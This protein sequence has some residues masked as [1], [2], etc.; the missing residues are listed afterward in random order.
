[1]IDRSGFGWLMAT[2]PRLYHVV[3]RSDEDARESVLAHGVVTGAPARHNWHGLWRPR[4]GH[5]YLATGAYVTRVRRWAHDG[6]YDVFAVD[7]SYLTAACINPDEDHFSGPDDRIG[8][9][10]AL[11]ANTIGSRHACQAFGLPFPPTPWLWN[12]ATR[13]NLQP[14]PS[15]GEW[16]EAVDLGSRPEQTRYSVTKGSLAYRGTVP[17]QAVTLLTPSPEGDALP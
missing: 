8:G 10:N 6:S 7:T 1:M 12:W 2:Y 16:A 4:P 15:Y 3:C 5:V 11:G 13:L 14:L 9:N 17:P